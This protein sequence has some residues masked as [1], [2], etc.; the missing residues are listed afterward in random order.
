[1]VLDTLKWSRSSPTKMVDLPKLNE[2]QNVFRIKITRVFQD[3][4]LSMSDCNLSA[5]AQSNYVLA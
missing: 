3:L 4:F 5:H 1:M 2:Q